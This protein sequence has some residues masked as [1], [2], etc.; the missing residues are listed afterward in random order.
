MNFAADPANEIQD[1]LCCI[2]KHSCWLFLWL[3]FSLKPITGGAAFHNTVAPDA[4]CVSSGT[5]FAI[6]L[7]SSFEKSNIKS[8]II[9]FAR[10]SLQS[11]CL[12][13]RSSARVSAVRPRRW[14]ESRV[15]MKRDESIICATM[16]RGLGKEDEMKLGWAL[17]A[18][19]RLCT[20]VRSGP[21][22]VIRFGVRGAP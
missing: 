14:L 15:N 2:A 10:E 20:L 9:V 6:C 16:S 21:S 13:R 4:S 3:I 22:T 5:C 18:G 11:S 8:A 7:H 17:R 12:H 19:R 1:C